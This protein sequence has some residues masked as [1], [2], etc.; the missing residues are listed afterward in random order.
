MPP[1]LSDFQIRQWLHASQLRLHKAEPHTLVLDELALCQGAARVDVAVIN[2]QLNG[3]EIKSDRDSLD[4]LP[5][6]IEVYNQ[7]LDTI[8]L[9]TGPRYAERVVERLP[10]W[11]GIVVAKSFGAQITF[12]IV[13]EQKCNVEC[14]AFAIAQL[15]WRDEVLDLLK[16]RNLHKGVKSK[17]RKILWEAAA[18]ELSTQELKDAVRAALKRR[19]DWRSSIDSATPEIQTGQNNAWR[20]RPLRSYPQIKIR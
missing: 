4:R 15:L 7:V 20:Q 12:E 6:Q 14:N 11:W 17:P 5:L 10:I 9:V 16:A 2:G 13:R 8:V 18:K 19:A 3:Y 1:K